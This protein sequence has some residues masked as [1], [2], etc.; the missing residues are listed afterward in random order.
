MANF[1]LRFRRLRD[2]VKRLFFEAQVKAG[3][4][5]YGR[6]PAPGEVKSKQR[7]TISAKVIRA[8]GS[9]EDLGVIARNS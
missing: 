1:L 9:V 5:T 7:S 4:K 2:K 8:N 6:Q 3:Q